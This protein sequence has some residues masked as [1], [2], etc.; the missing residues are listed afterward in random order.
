MQFALKEDEGC[1]G[2]TA[3]LVAAKSQLPSNRSVNFIKPYVLLSL[4]GSSSPPKFT[5]PN[6]TPSLRKTG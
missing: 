3:S 5:S 6:S 4:L 2:G 1:E